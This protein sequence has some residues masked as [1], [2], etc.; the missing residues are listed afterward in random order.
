[1]ELIQRD[2]SVVAT[3]NA[4]QDIAVRAVGHAYGLAAVVAVIRERP[5]YVSY[6]TTAKIL[7]LA[8]QLLKRAG[9]HDTHIA[10]IE[11]EVAWTLL[12]ALMTLGPNFVR[13]QLPQLLVLWR[14]ALPKPTSKDSDANAGRTA[15]EW[16]FLLHVRENA[17]GAIH[18][19]LLH[20]SSS[21]V[22]LDVAR[23][24]ASLLTNVFAFANAFISQTID[25]SGAGDINASSLL[26]REAA[27]RRRI[28]QCFSVLGFSGVSD[29][30]QSALLQSAVAQFASPTGYIGS[31]MQA[32]IASS[33]GDMTS[34]SQCHD[35]YAYGVSSIQLVDLEGTTSVEVQQG[36]RERL[37]R[38]AV[39]NALDN[40]VSFTPSVV[41]IGANMLQST[42]PVLQSMEHDSL[43]VCTTLH[44][45]TEL[46]FVE[47]SPA[48]TGVVDAAIQLFGALLTHQGVNTCAST[49]QQILELLRSPKLERNN[50]RRLAVTT[51]STIAIVAALRD[52]TSRRSSKEVVG[53]PTVVS[54]LYP[55]LLVRFECRFECMIGP[56]RQI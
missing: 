8:V 30:T 43:L 23:R 56:H 26:S 7:D 9:T 18:S 29:S 6:D 38:D 47:S 48:A 3:P 39:E 41:T 34:L 37:N 21:L 2:I 33:A 27:L 44:T 17:L 42:L 50:G 46:R 16:L 11:I 19:F 22:T 10:A 15:A 12:A 1:M 35:G 20:N 14:N 28:Y 52:A 4:P 51:N 24:I 55:L 13:S 25:V 49:L 5:L 32:A 40:A 45:T 53:H 54:T 36:Q 31:A